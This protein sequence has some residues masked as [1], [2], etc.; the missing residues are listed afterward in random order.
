MDQIV[1]H[2][3]DLLIS[4]TAGQGI[5][6]TIRKALTNAP[7]RLSSSQQQSLER[8]NR[9]INR[10]GVFSAATAKRV[11]DI[12]A[13]SMPGANCMTAVYRGL[14]GLFSK[15]A[16][17]SIESQVVRESREVMRETG[18]DTN[19]M[20][21]IME[22]VRARGMA[23]PATQLVYRAASDTWQPDP[24]S[25]VLGMTHPNVAGWYFFGL[26][27]HAAFHSVILAADKTDPA[28]P[29]LYWMD[30][31]SRGFTND[32]TGTLMDEMRRFRPSYG[33]SPSRLWQII[34]AA[35]TLII[36]D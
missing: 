2:Q 36:L 25:T 30:Q 17:Q 21:R 16:S 23:G 31:Y 10:L 35:N 20:D 15:G 34:P 7:A 29:H 6:D 26:S 14:E 4:Q 8:A 33:F 13:T 11:R 27:L 3:F 1:I 5:I 24:E 22:T 12:Y 19:H 32:V 18:R 9:L 28:S